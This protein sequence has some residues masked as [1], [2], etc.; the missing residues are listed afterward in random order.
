GHE[1]SC[2]DA[3]VPQIVDHI[4]VLRVQVSLI[5]SYTARRVRRGGGIGRG[6]ALRGDRP[7]GPIQLAAG[8]GEGFLRYVRITSL[9]RHNGSFAPDSF[10]K[11]RAAVKT[12]R[13]P[14]QRTRHSDACPPGTD[15]K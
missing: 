7:G 4:R 11:K 14:C 6:L 3:H 1:N 10:S 13:P 5:H 12:T 15:G 9:L 2:E 8:A